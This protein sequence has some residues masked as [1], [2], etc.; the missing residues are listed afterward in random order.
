VSVSKIIL[1]DK[2]Q[3]NREGKGIRLLE[4]AARYMSCGTQRNHR[5]N[6]IPT[7]KHL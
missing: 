6:I 4:V 2:F 1:I 5:R 7:P 3:K